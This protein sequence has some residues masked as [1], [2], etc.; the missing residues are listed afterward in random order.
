MI[1]SLYTAVSGIS[2]NGTA[3]TVI[4]DNIANLNTIGFKG[5]RVA[6]GD[7]LSQTL[8]GGSSQIG[9]GVLVSDVSALFSQ[10]SFQTSA[11]VLDLAIDGEGF[12]IVK[13]NSGA[14]YY[15]RA[16]QFSLNKDGF[17][18]NPEGLFLQ[19][20]LADSTG[21]ILGEINSLE[22]GTTQSPPRLT[23]NAKIGV[24]LDATAIPPANPF[25]LDGNGDGNDDDPANFSSSTTITVFDSQGGAHTITLYFVKTG[26]NTWQVNY[27]YSNPDTTSP[28]KLLLAGTQ[29][30]TFD[31]NGALVNDNDDTPINF[32]FGAAV[33]SPQPIT[34]DFGTGT[35]ETPPGTGLDGSTQFASPFSVL[36]I[37]QDGY[38]A[39][40]L[41]TV[42]V[43]ENGIITGIF[44]NGQTRILGQ[45]ALARF[46]APT[47]LLKMGRNLFAETFESGQ[48]IVGNPTTS[49]LGRVLSNT[50]E[51]SNVDLAE[52]FIKMIS[53]QRGFQANSRMVTA[54]DDLMQEL[55][56]MKR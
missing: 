1:T 48:P 15:T 26:D 30:I 17:I 27:V 55:V 38:A 28:D 34:F 47:G 22:L 40:S 14:R 10:G 51:L 20:Y 37:S 42:T 8:A 53:A 31:T 12:F 18:V 7:I 54:V 25:T 4:G 6:F 16:G 41:K 56:N 13:D 19:G 50:L 43:S 5:S 24:N 36:S 23:V 44:T 46:V 9:R 21:K 39:G 33:T 2:A 52:E 11:S 32:N 29:T 45:I 35:G 49:G 3:L